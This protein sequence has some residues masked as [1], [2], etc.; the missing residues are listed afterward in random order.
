[1]YFTFKDT[2]EINDAS[3]LKKFILDDSARMHVELENSR[4]I[5]LVSRKIYMCTSTRTCH[6]QYK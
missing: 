2:H 6:V 5:R 4:V 3:L 1:M